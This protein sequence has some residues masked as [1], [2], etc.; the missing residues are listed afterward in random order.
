MTD[1]IGGNALA[2]LRHHLLPGLW[3]LLVAFAVCAIAV[4]LMIWVSRRVGMMAMPGERHPH[5]KPTPL[6][7]GV[8]LYLGFAAA[9]LFFLPSYKDTIGVLVVTGLATFL[10]IA[11]DR[12]QVRAAIKL[13]LQF[14][15]ALVAIL[16]FGFKITSFGLPGD[17]V[18]Q[19]YWLAI[20]VTVFWLLGMQN[21]VNLLD[22]VDGL[23]AGVIFIVAVTL[24]L[25]AAGLQNLP[26]LEMAG[27]LAGTCLGFLIFNFYPARIFMGD[28]G[29][30]FLG[31]ALAVVAVLGVAKVAVAFALVVPVLALALPIADT[32][33]AI[34]RRRRQGRSV[35]MPDLRH[36]HHRL[37][38]FGL[39]ARQTCYVFYA[40]SAI[41]GA[42][43]LTLFGHG[44][45]LAVVAATS[46]ALASTVAADLLQKTGWRVRVPYLRRLL[47]EPTRR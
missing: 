25:A 3:P 26:A 11:D 10:L 18:V 38:A 47:A 19:L 4:P 27:A 13:G 24:M 44:R 42:L 30:H 7:G 17:F 21:T 46:V 36:L 5:M 39:D 43:G 2:N 14:L 29:A 37:Q 35:A 34:F 16:V 15:I 12:W 20:P 23:A 40:A 22:G 33:W 45:I 31:T 32:G 41:L 6:L 8:A 28:S 1:F 9:L